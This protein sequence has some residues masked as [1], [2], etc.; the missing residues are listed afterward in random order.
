MPLKNVTCPGFYC[1][2]EE[3]CHAH[4]QEGD[5]FKR[6]WDCG[7]CKIFS[8]LQSMAA[9]IFST[10]ALTKSRVNYLRVI[11]DLETLFK[12]HFELWDQEIA[13]VLIRAADTN[14]PCTPY[15]SQFSKLEPVQPRC[16][17]SEQEQ[18][19]GQCIESMKCFETNCWEDI[20]SRLSQ[21]R[22]SK[23]VLG[24]MASGKNLLFNSCRRCF[25][26]GWHNRQ[27]RGTG[28]HDSLVILAATAACCYRKLL[29]RKGTGPALWGW[30][31]R[32]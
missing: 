14:N 25:T 20:R 4:N 19:R 10:V 31:N 32:S 28:M 8:S 30:E 13:F 3:F 5:V 2:N 6:E 1:T 24:F 7:I 23:I 15:G 12:M 18:V 21:I 11:K 17:W 29:L 16:F 27:W 26:I 9:Y 22:T